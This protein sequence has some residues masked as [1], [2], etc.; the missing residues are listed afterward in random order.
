LVIIPHFSI[1]AVSLEKLLKPILIDL[2]FMLLAKPG[3]RDAPFEKRYGLF[4]ARARNELRQHGMNPV[5]YITIVDAAG[6]FLFH[7]A[8]ETGALN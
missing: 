1:A 2:R 8:P 3:L 4:S 7:I 6:D 5:Q